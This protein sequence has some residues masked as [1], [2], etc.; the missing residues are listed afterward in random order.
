MH[1][2]RWVMVAMLWVVASTYVIAEELNCADMKSPF[3]MTIY[4][5]NDGT[6]VKPNN[7]QD[8]HYT[9]AIKL[10]VTHQ[11]QWAKAMAR[12]LPFS[13]ASKQEKIKTAGGYAIGQNIYTPDPIESSTL[14][15]SERPWA[16]WLYGSVYVQRATDRVFDQFEI[17][18]GVIGP[19]SLAEDVQRE[20]HD[21]FNQIEP[22]GWDYQLSDEFGIDFIYQRKWKI[23][24]L[25]IQGRDSMQLIPQAGFT[26]GLV[27]RHVNA[28][29]LMR[30][31]VN[32]PDDFGPGRIEEPAAATG[33]PNQGSG[34]YFFVR[35]GGKIV[36]HNIFLDG[37]NYHSSHAVDSESLFGEVQIGVVLLLGRFEVD[38]SQ[39]FQSREF[40]GQRDKDSF[41]SLTLSW[42]SS[43]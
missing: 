19:S 32:L 10:S 31:G 21:L 20:V 40:K 1:R 17:N 6:F 16:G 12:W 9:N 36:E 43:F 37:N 7:R 38:Y 11:P 14:I 2:L 30:M 22:R 41:G 8:R 25:T 24:L 5:E 42:R 28:G 39:T 23:P 15:P 34:G 33:D 3:L 4:Y 29:L 26:L 35:A 13:P 18:L 27:H